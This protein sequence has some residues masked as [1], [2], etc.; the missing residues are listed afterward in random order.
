MA[1]HVV[2]LSQIYR[3]Q[4]YNYQIFGNQVDGL[5]TSYHL[6]VYRNHYQ[7][8]QDSISILLHTPDFLS[9]NKRRE[10]KPIV[11]IIFFSLLLIDK[12]Q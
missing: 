7:D 12:L 1:S 2:R 5:H 3:Y 4:F 10:R 9:H 8:F 6:H 11:L